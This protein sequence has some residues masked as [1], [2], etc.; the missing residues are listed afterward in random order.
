[1]D[2]GPLHG[3]RI[4]DLTDERGIFSAK[5]LGDLGADVVRPEPPEG[6]PLRQRGPHLDGD[7]SSLWYAFFATSRRFLTIDPERE[8]DRTLLQQ[9]VERADVLL[10]CPGTFA[11]EH[12]D[13]AATRCT[14]PQLVHVDVSSFGDDGPRHGGQPDAALLLQSRGP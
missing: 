11:V 14:N 7:G 6:D 2:K 12:V 3:M 10:T 4:I 9:L 8:A 13:L 5:L 1:M